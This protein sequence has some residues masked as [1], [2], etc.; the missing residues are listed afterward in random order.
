MCE[1]GFVGLST[2]AEMEK[3]LQES[4]DSVREAKIQLVML[5]QS[6]VTRYEF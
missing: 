6:M 5:D 1:L 2:P 3:I 4:R